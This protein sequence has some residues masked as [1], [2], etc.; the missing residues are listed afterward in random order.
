M[1]V[2][3]LD[4]RTLVWKAEADDQLGAVITAAVHRRTNVNERS[5]RSA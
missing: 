5:A 2:V 3:L 4:E 1:N